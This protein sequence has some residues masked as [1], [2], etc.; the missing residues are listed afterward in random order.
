MGEQSWS[1]GHEEEPDYTHPRRVPRPDRIL[2]HRARAQ[3]APTRR[4]LSLSRPRVLH[5]PPSSATWPRGAAQRAPLLDHGWRLP[6]GVRGGARSSSSVEGRPLQRVNSS[7][8]TFV[9][10]PLCLAS[11]KCSAST[12]GRLTARTWPSER[13]KRIHGPLDRPTRGEF[14]D[15]A[16]RARGEASRKLDSSPRVA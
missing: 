15:A 13:L 6:A 8:G 12:W 14:C 1:R 4:C 11:R 16:V 5:G 7:G 2:P 9:F 3:H 10:P